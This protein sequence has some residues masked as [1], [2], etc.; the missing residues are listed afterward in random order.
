[1]SRTIALRLDDSTYTICSSVA[2]K[3]ES[4]DMMATVRNCGEILYL[5]THHVSEEDKRRTGINRTIIPGVKEAASPCR[6]TILSGE[7]CAVGAIDAGEAVRSTEAPTK[8]VSDAP[9]AVLHREQSPSNRVCYYLPEFD[10][11]IIC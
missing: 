5:R 3:L 8:A 4:E 10:L 2:P 6:I 1:M 9:T 11:K 7:Q